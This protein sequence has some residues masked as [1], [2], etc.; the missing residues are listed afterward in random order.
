MYVFS[1][2]ILFTPLKNVRGGRTEK[3]LDRLA[4]AW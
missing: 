2:S 1:L 4:L 3:E